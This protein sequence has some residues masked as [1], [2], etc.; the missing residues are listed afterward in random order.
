MPAKVNW[1]IVQSST[2]SDAPLLKTMPVLPV[3]PPTMVRP[4][5]TTLSL[6]PAL[7]VTA[8]PPPDAV[9]AAVL[10]WLTMLTA[11]VIVT[12]PYPA[13]SSTEIS[14]PGLVWV[15][16]K[17][18]V[19]QGCSTE[20]GLVSAPCAETKVRCAAASA[21]SGY[22]AAAAASRR[23]MPFIDPSRSCFSRQN[24][25]SRLRKNVAVNFRRRRATGGCGYAARKKRLALSH[26]SFFRVS[27][28]SVFHARMLS[29]VCGNWHSEWG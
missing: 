8:L 13:V 19:R 24:G 16:A 3:P 11:W 12:G 4:R 1:L 17:A 28:F 10:V 27:G 23:N 20:H 15:R 22:R 6:A 9:I 2:L 29:T 14:P 18:K 5:R 7:T 25:R 21:A 26:I